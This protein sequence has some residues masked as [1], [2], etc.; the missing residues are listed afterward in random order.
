[1]S[2]ASIS[3]VQVANASTKTSSREDQSR[4]RAP[5]IIPFLTIW[6]IGIAASVGALMMTQEW[7]LQRRSEHFNLFAEEEFHKIQ[8]HL[9]GVA[10]N[11]RAVSGLFRASGGVHR[12]EF[13]AFVEAV[14]VAEQIRA[15]AWVPRVPEELRSKYEQR[16]QRAGYPGFTF[17]ERTSEG[18]LDQAGDR[19]EYFPIF[20]L[21][22]YL[23]NESA[24]GFDLGSDAAILSGLM[25]SR[26]TGEEIASSGITLVEEPNDQD[27]V[28]LFSPTY[29]TQAKP[30]SNTTDK[31]DLV[32]FGLGVFR[33][34]DL[35][36]SALSAEPPTIE[37]AIFD[38]SAPAGSQRLYPTS[39]RSESANN[40]QSPFYRETALSLGTQEWSLV[41]TAA[42]DSEFTEES[43]IPWLVMSLGFVITTLTA[44]F[45]GSIISRNQ[46]ANFLV[47]TKTADLV[48]SNLEREK[49]LQM[50]EEM[51]L[52]DSLTGLPNRTLFLDRLDRSVRLGRREKQKFAILMMDLNGFKEINDT[53]GHE[54]GDELLRVVAKRMKEVS[55]DC[56]TVAR[57]GGD[58]FSALLPSVVSMEGASIL[59]DR[60]Q[61]S[62]V[63]PVSLSGRTLRVGISVGVGLFPD[64]G[65][66]RKSLLHSADMA[67]YRA[68][69]SAKLK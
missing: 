2:L 40:S 25:K 52:H 1:M 32:G 48:K 11:V 69:K 9:L 28:F 51:S 43:P 14:E 45:V 44:M 8:M 18:T 23:D 30:R 57:L 3:P 22:P 34:S 60:I 5:G 21:E 53:Y 58:E 59:A 37:I 49:V 12:G 33:F 66:D 63:R 7:D 17:T 68:K 39:S 55:R 29:R 15:L 47:D 54:V 46:Y 24:L 35:V 36:S 42:N 6:M 20:F 64:H 56:D 10:S 27:D 41:A 13:H 61:D 4:Q 19:P 65:Q 67:M 62:V 31:P 50:L 38:K 16:A 26:A